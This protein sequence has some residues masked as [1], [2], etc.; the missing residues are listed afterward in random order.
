MTTT[1]TYYQVSCVFYK[2][3]TGAADNGCFVKTFRFNT[4]SKAT[5][6]AELIKRCK[7]RGLDSE[8]IDKYIG[9]SSGGIIEG[10][11]RVSV[12]T[13]ESTDVEVV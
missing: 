11:P 1:E 2:Y 4:L 3:N 5:H 7:G 10:S 9:W 6:F 12:N 8:F 13:L